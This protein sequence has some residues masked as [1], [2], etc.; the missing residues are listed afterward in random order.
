MMNRNQF[1]ISLLLGVVLVGMTA[2]QNRKEE[3]QVFQESKSATSADGA[4]DSADKV[5]QILPS[6][7]PSVEL[8]A[9][10]SRSAP[11]ALP[12]LVVEEQLAYLAFQDCSD[13]QAKIPNA[14]SGL[15]KVFLEDENAQIISYDAYCDFEIAGEAWTL[16]LNYVHLANTEPSLVVRAEGFP[17]FRNSKLGD[18][19]QASQ[20]WGHSSP[21][22][23]ANFAIRE[24]RFFCQASS[25]ARIIHFKTSNQACIDYIQTGT[26]SCSEISADFVPYGDHS[27]EL[28]GSNLNSQADAGDFA[29]TN[30]IFRDQNAT[31][32]WT[33]AAGGGANDDWE[34]DDDIDNASQS[35]I[36]RV[37][38]R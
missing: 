31:R 1:N 24:L 35:T 8:E 14:K 27:A 19:E 33:L 7:E 16:I 23:L 29:L 21:G 30:R 22:F 38:F 4:Q 28:P 10:P 20:T 37:W 2:C 5:P 6:D 3:A 26:G 17:G 9:E 32:H 11:E 15:Y 13:V 25:H 12:V 36:H 34:C 18:D